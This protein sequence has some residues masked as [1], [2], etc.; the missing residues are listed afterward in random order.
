MGSAGAASKYANLC[1][2]LH[3][4]CVTCMCVDYG[5]CSMFLLQLTPFLSAEI[6]QTRYNLA[7]KN[8]PRAICSSQ[9]RTKFGRRSNLL[10]KH[11]ISFGSF[12]ANSLIS[13]ETL[14]K[15]SHKKRFF[16]FYSTFKVLS[17]PPGLLPW[18]H[19]RWIRGRL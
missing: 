11:L 3:G 14:F 6:K 7:S 9:D 1:H 19:M 4:S 16:S 17:D 15:L 5:N 2:A 8:A 12:C 13:D 18:K 10:R